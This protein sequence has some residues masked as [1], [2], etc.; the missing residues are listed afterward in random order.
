[1]GNVDSSP[2]APP[3]HHH[4]GAAH[5]TSSVYQAANGNGHVQNSVYGAKYG[6]HNV[7]QVVDTRGAPIGFDYVDIASALESISKDDMERR[8]VE[9][10]VSHY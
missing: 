3:S 10:V 7:H 1:M 5:S 6:A 2:P 8:F 9:I 4:A